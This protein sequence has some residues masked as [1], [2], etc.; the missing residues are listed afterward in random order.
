MSFELG[1][2]SPPAFGF[3]TWTEPALTV[4]KLLDLEWK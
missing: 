2:Q 4:L 1:H 3:H